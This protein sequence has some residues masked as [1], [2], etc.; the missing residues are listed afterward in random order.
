MRQTHLLYVA[1]NDEPRKK[2]PNAHFGKR[3]G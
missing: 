2:S 1:D 3:S